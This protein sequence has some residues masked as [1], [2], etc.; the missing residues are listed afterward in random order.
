V[1]PCKNDARYLPSALESI[2]SQDYAH[3][4]C[5][6]VD[7]GSTDGTI[8][9]LKRY[10][11]RIRWLSQPD[12]GSFD[13]INRGWKLSQGE[14]LTWLNAD[15]LWAP[16]AVR[17]AVEV[18]ERKLEVDVV[19]GT[20]GVVDELGRFQ[21]DLVPPEWD[22]EYALRH[23]LHLIYQPASFMRRRILE[24]VGW[25]YP[26]WC[27]DHDLWLRIA[28]AGGTFE[29]IPVRLG[30]DRMRSEN[31]GSLAKIVIPA[32]I[33]LTKRFFADPGLPPNLQR[34]RRRAI[35]SAYVRAVDYLLVHRPVHWLLAV[36]FL[37][38]AILTNPLNIHSIKERGT[39]PF[40]YHGLRLLSRMKFGIFTLVT[41]IR[42]RLFRLIAAVLTLPKRWLGRVVQRVFVRGT[43]SSHSRS[44]ILSA[45]SRQLIGRLRQRSP[46]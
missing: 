27:H 16:G 36:R 23:C 4:E 25:L 9:L 29:K 34:L 10:S 14:I 38:Q 19:F 35:S 46:R 5:I 7:G 20:A 39:R 6:V 18:F 21:G 26:A 1:V 15:D 30:M 24:K 45:W 12:R 17:S 42:N 8:D 13:A 33:A 11:D 44:I 31:L 28:R 40:R 2:L 37:L 3:V 22:L 32:K 43:V 41:A